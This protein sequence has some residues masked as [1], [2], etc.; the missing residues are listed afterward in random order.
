MSLSFDLP[1]PL[2]FFGVS[3]NELEFVQSED[4]SSKSG[5]A[6]PGG[7]ERSSFSMSFLIKA[8]TLLTIGSCTMLGFRVLLKGI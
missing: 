8:V 6:I 4:N 5:R 3:A 7:S 2:L 1:L